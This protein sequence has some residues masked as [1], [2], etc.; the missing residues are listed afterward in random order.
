VALKDG[1]HGPVGFEE[2]ASSVAVEAPDGDSA[3]AT[4]IQVHVQGDVRVA[5]GLEEVRPFESRIVVGENDGVTLPS[6]SVMG[7]CVEDVEADDVTGGA[8]GWHSVSGVQT[9]GLAADACIASSSRDGLDGASPGSRGIAC[10]GRQVL[11]RARIP[12]AEAVVEG[13]AVNIEAVLCPPFSGLGQKRHGE[14]DVLIGEYE[15]AGIDERRSAAI[16]EG[17]EGRFGAKPDVHGEHT[18]GGGV[19]GG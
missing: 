6:A 17:E 11:E 18:F 2:F 3:R 13:V 16:A 1:S 5:L 19:A 14:L 12:V 10:G 9:M 4:Q 8:C 15:D 7:T